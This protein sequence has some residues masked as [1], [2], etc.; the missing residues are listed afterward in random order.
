MVAATLH[1]RGPNRRRRK[2]AADVADITDDIS[3]GVGFRGKHLSAQLR[4]IRRI[5]SNLGLS[6]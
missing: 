1:I 6:G 3:S 4:F 2:D 5:R